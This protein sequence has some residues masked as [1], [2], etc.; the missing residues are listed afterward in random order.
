MATSLLNPYVGG[1]DRGAGGGG[2]ANPVGGISAPGNPLTGVKRPALNNPVGVPKG[3]PAFRGRSVNPG[4]KIKVPKLKNGNL[5]NETSN[6]PIPYSRVCPLEFLS[7]FTGRLSPGDVCFVDQYPPGFVTGPK[8]GAN[9]NNATLGVNSMTRVVGLDGLNRI[10]TGQSAPSGW[11]VG[12]NV[13]EVDKDAKPTGVVDENGNFTLKSLSRYRLDGVVRNND[14]PFAS[15][16]SGDRDAAIFNN[17]VQGPTLVNNGFLYY[18]PK[19]EEAKK[20]PLNNM[21]GVP[22][23]RA[24]E[25]F[26]RGS[27]EGGYH[28]AGTGPPGRV[29]SPWLGSNGYDYVAN[30]TGT[31]TVFPA[32]M[33]DR[34]LRTLDTLYLGLRA[35]KVP[36]A[37][38]DRVE[39][40]DE[41]G[42]EKDY[43]YFQYMPFSSRYAWLAQI[44]EAETAKLVAGGMGAEEAKAKARNQVTYDYI[45]TQV[46][47]GASKFRFDEGAFDAVRTDDLRNMTGGW[48]LGKVMDT[49]AMRYDT[50]AGGPAD[51]AYAAMVNIGISWRSCF[52]LE[53][54]PPPIKYKVDKEG[55]YVLD[56]DGERVPLPYDPHHRRGHITWEK[57]DKVPQHQKA[58]AYA[59]PLSKVIGPIM[60]A[61]L[62]TKGG[63]GGGGG[64]DGVPLE[65]VLERGFPEDREGGEEEEEEEEEEEV[66]EDAEEE[67]GEEPVSAPAAPPAMAALQAVEI[68]AQKRAKAEKAA[69]ATAAAEAAR[70]EAAAIAESKAAKAA[71]LSA[72]KSA[73]TGTSASAGKRAATPKRSV[74]PKRPGAGAAAPTGAAA[75][76]AAA[77][78]PPGAAGVTSTPLIPTSAAPASTTAALDRDVGDTPLRRREREAAGSS[79]VSAAFETVFGRSP[80]RTEA[81]AAP[82]LT[83]PASPTPSSESGD[84]GSGGPNIFQRPR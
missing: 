53:E 41:A 6:I 37:S 26:A 67:P 77:A 81:P 3:L 32:Q 5:N 42:G 47:P 76:T 21:S 56:K 46:G 69:A 28:I 51:T 19:G 36:A 48:V 16:H 73:A 58:M 18:N 24:V 11:K 68:A 31:Y 4:E 74:T 14:E 59:P 65:E 33:F 2:G 64:R 78:P 39:G 80:T 9:F 62:R 10:L 70:L 23:S 38:L 61:D 35:F 20:E 55:R 7:G 66:F 30:F 40:K 82:V 52:E 43:Y 79:A 12:V 27:A 8:N 13:L 72:K 17:I 22:D 44:V 45:T 57:R 25:A 1:R 49:K 34:H 84:G 29:G 50:Y 54:V 63:G 83:E 15:T 75:S 71:A 60:G